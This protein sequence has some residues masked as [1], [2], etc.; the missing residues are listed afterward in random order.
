MTWRTWATSKN[1]AIAAKALQDL[2]GVPRQRPQRFPHYGCTRCG[3][4]EPTHSTELR[5]GAGGICPL[6]EDCWTDLETPE[7]RMPYYRSLWILWEVENVASACDT[8]GSHE[9]GVG[10]GHCRDTWRDVEAAVIAEA[11]VDPEGLR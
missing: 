7:A 8:F 4:T 11:S 10:V 6:C 9:C 1:V 5:N 2:E 3:K